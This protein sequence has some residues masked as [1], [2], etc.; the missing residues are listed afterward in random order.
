MKKAAH[1][2]RFRK[3]SEATVSP[4]NVFLRFLECLTVHKMTNDDTESR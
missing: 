4:L 3:S 2:Q 1:Y